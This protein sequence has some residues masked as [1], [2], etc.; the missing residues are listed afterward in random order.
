MKVKVI[1]RQNLIYVH[2]NTY[3]ISNEDI[4]ADYYVHELILRN[5]FLDREH[6]TLAK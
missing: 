2:E 5:L 6:K 1:Y 4:S 3:N